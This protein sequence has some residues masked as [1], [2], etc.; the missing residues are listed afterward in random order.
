VCRG[1]KAPWGALDQGGK[2]ARHINLNQ[3]RAFFH[4]AK[5]LSF[6][7]RV[8]RALHYTTC[9]HAQVNLFEDYCGLKLFKKKS[10][11]LFLREE[12]K[13]DTDHIIDLMLKGFSK[14]VLMIKALA[15]VF[16]FL[17]KK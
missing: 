16:F 9:R 11:R 1:F 6:H 13:D 7:R 5:R 17:I 15:S 10:G 3:L 12:G 2:T 8:K 14:Q 4:A